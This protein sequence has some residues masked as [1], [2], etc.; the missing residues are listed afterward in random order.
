MFKMNKQVFIEKQEDKGL[1]KNLE[2][3][4]SSAIIMW[5]IPKKGTIS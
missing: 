3:H 1:K 4:V 5:P 2:W